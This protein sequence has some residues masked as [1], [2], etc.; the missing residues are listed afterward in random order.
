SGHIQSLINPPGNPKAKF[1]SN[2]Q[3]PANADAW[4]AAAKAESDS[5]WGDWRDWL[6][7]RSGDRKE[8]PGTLGNAGHAQLAR[9]PGTYVFES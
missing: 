4:L 7:A 1:F 6:A 3:L 2:S 5:W 8:A 9:A